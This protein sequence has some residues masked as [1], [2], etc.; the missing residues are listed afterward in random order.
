MSGRRRANLA[1]LFVLGFL[2]PAYT[3]T[4]FD[5]SA[6]A[7]EETV[8]AAENVPRGIVRS[9]A[10]SG[11]AGW[12]MLAAVVLAVPDLDAA[13]AA[14][15][16]AFAWIMGAVLPA[17]AGAGLERGHRAGAVRL[18]T[19]GHDLGLADG[20]RL[21]PRRRTARLARL[22]LGQPPAADPGRGDLGGGRAGGAVHAEHA[23]LCDDHRRLHDLPLHLLRAPHGARGLGYGRT[24]T[25]MG[26]WDLGRWYRPLACL[27]VL[28]CVLLIAIGMQT[29]LR[30]G[31]LDRRPVP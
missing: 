30:P 25:R 29:A 16:V 9:V 22:A 8:G 5:A 13:A 12:V 17:A 7:A 27:S 11:L 19:G 2:L 14:G 26:P 31:R 28:G 18:R 15:R 1:W 23:G 10:V 24:W 21:R 6:H 20:V 4:G 3:I